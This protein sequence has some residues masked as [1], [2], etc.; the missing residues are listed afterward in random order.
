MGKGG[1]RTHSL[2]QIRMSRF[3]HDTTLPQSMYTM[4]GLGPASDWN[5]LMR[6]T[7]ISGV[8]LLLLLGGCGG[9]SDERSS[10]DVEN[11]AG[12]SSASCV[13]RVLVDG[14]D[15]TGWPLKRPLE[16]P[17]VATDVPGILP[18]CDDLDGD[19]QVADP[20]EEVM[21]RPIKGIAPEAVLFLPDH[22]LDDQIFV[23]G[24]DISF[25]SLPPEVRSLIQGG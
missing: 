15:W 2:R 10:S 1:E 5:W 3:G 12:T 23:P 7:S 20:D 24:M 22:D 8:A 18:G 13:L 17:T 4:L 11:N 21:L 9:A 16:R 19:G 6:A 14:K 25:E